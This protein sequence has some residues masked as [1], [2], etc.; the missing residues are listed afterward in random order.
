MGKVLEVLEPVIVV[1]GSKLYDIF[2]FAIF[3]T[4]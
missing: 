3:S 1:A 4:N 2:L